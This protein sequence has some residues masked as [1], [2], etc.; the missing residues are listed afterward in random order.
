MVELD[1]Q[2]IREAV[3]AQI[4]HVEADV[5]WLTPAGNPRKAPLYVAEISNEYLGHHK[6]VKAGSEDELRRKLDTQLNRWAEQ[7]V[8]RRISD[9]KRDLKQ[10]ALD[11]SA[12][13]ESTIDALRGI[14]AATLD[15]DDKI[16]WHSLRDV[17]PY[18]HEFTF[19]PQP[20]A[21]EPPKRGLADFLVPF[22]WRR[23]KREYSE[24]LTRHG[25]RT[26]EWESERES[27]LRTFQEKRRHYERQQREHNDE[28]RR[29]Q[30]DFE[31][32]SPEAVC[33]YVRRV[34]ESSSYPDDVA[35][36][37]EVAVSDDQRTLVVDVG[38]PNQASLP[39]TKSLRYVASRNR[40]EPVEMKRAEHDDLYDEV[41]K[42]IALRTM[43]ECFESLYTDHVDAVTVN[44]WVTAIDPSTGREATSCILSIMSRRSEFEQLDLAHVDAS[45]CIRGMKGLVAGPL[46]NVAPVKPIMELRRDD[47]RFVE[48]QAVLADL[49]ATTN[50]AEIPWEDFEHLVRELFE[51]MFSD[52]DAEVK[53]TQASRDAGVDA[54]VFDSDPIRGGKFVIQAKRYTNV[55]GVAAVRDLYGTMINEGAVKGILVTTSH[56]GPDSLAFAKDK[57]LTLIDGSN[58]VHM[59]DQYGHNVRI[60]VDA[61]RRNRRA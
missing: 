25:E 32:G 33:E 15:V 43:H 49:N 3:F 58:L 14:L 26:R 13:I 23:R 61:A 12:D 8:R 29:F 52:G 6:L 39:T 40:I 21:N 56:Y 53:V 51:R 36:T 17:R 34:F 42:Q 44:G 50:L 41:L 4:V 57:P 48:S 11:E 24:H 19:R 38:M 7:E 28:L 9:A 31:S 5:E 1:E 16:D 35:L 55:V 27:A 45:A 22:R 59:L 54:I 18:P 46:C 10:Q 20:K 37:Y 47:S 2:Q 60:D 30:R